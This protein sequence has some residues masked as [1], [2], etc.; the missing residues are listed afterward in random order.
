[1]YDV[2]M[3]RD[4]RGISI[5]KVGVRGVHLPLQIRRKD[6]GYQMVL[7]HVDMTVELPHHYRGTHMSRFLEILSE[8]SDQPISGHELRR[9]LREAQQKLEADRA[10]LHLRFKYF[11]TKT[12][13]VSG[14]ESRLDYDC[15]FIGRIEGD[16]YCFILGVEVPVIALCPCSKEISDRGAHN[17]R[18]TLRAHVR[19]APGHFVWIED[20]VDILEAQGSCGIYPL[21][22]REDEK[23]VTEHSYDN[24]KYVEDILRDAVVALKQEQHIVW[25]DVECDSHES[26]HNHSAY[27]YWNSDNA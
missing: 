16:R 12:A 19:C 17:Q 15:D 4:P 27:A 5:Q 24:P 26:I 8:W 14:S 13:P 11:R 23:Y 7:G 2:S 22:K 21:L 6:N 1:M 9:I 18:A 3:E 25:F 20:L 10:D